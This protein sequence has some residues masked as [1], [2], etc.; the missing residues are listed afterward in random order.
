MLRPLALGA[1]VAGAVAGAGPA[2]G[3]LPDAAGGGSRACPL[4]GALQEYVRPWE[5]L[6]GLRPRPESAFLFLIGKKLYRA[7]LER[8]R[9][10][11]EASMLSSTLNLFKGQVYFG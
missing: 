4:S 10:E 7:S 3:G 1:E 11:G 8:R 5:R 9:G 2:P 6:R